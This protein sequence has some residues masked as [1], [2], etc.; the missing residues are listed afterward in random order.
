MTLRYMVMFLDQDAGRSQN[1][2]LC[3]SF[4]ER[5]ELFRYLGTTVT[6]QNYIREEIKSRLKAGSV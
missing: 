6:Y 4:S 1:V 3:N 5:V 2:K